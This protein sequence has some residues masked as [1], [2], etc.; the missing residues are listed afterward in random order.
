MSESEA[1]KKAAEMGRRLKGLRVSEI[2]I[3]AERNLIREDW[4]KLYKTLNGS[5]RERATQI[6]WSEQED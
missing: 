4:A 1:V 5:E 2:A 3:R 6:Y